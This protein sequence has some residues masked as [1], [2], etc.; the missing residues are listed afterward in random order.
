VQAKLASEAERF[1]AELS[2]MRSENQQL[3]SRAQAL[4]DVQ[5]TSSR[6]RKKN[7]CS[8]NTFYYTNA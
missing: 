7:S 3:A 5:A 1:E 8:G 6:K 2:E 4:K